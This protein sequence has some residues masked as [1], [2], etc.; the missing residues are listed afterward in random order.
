MTIINIQNCY[1]FVSTDEQTNYK[2]W[3]AL[4]HREKNYFHSTLYKRKLWDGYV[5][6]YSKKTGRFLTGLLPEVEMALKIWGVDYQIEDSRTPFEFAY[7]NINNQFLNNWLPKGDSPVTLYDYQVDLINKIIEFKRGVIQAPTSAGK[8][9]ILLGLLHAL[10]PNTPTMI[11]ANTKS[12]VNQIYKDAIRWGI[13]NVGR[14]YD[15]YKEP[16][17]ITCSTI[18]S[19]HKMERVLPKIKAMFVDEIHLGMSKVPKKWYDKMTGC[20]VRTA[21]SATPFKFGGKDK[22]QKFSVKGYFGPVMRTQSGVLTTEMLQKRKILSSSKCVFYPIHEPQLPFDTYQDAVTNGIANNL[23][24]H[25]TVVQLAKS[26]KGRTLIMVERIAH[27]D[28]LNNLLPGSLWVQGK[29]NL[30]SRNYVIDS[31]VK[32]KKDVVAIATQGIFNAGINVK[33]HNL[34]NAASGQADH[35]IVQRMGR[36]LR[37]AEDKDVLNYYDFI[38]AINDYLYEH[39]MKRIKILTAEGHDVSISEEPFL[40]L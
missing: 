12:L 16:N 5:D 8:T 38:F 3:K 15:K 24:L 17:V 30:E 14:L 26:L 4:R 6:F 36:G 9:L 27:G 22:T 13:P 21:I 25:K 35:Q 11:L 29:D 28:A 34:I 19:M 18:Q 10:P 40:N 31:L 23:Y 1:S 33:V 7:K 39:S 37:T 2:L 20:V 32:S